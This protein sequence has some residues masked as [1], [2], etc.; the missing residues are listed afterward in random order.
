MTLF[1]W[2]ALERVSNN[3]H[4]GGGLVVVAKNEARARELANLDPDIDLPESE[5]VSHA[6]P[7]LG[8]DDQEDI[9]TFPDAG[10]C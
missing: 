1:I 5:P 6:Y 8:N 7:L 2:H 10:C 4:P 3:H 9:W